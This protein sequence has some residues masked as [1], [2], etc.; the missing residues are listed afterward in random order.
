MVPRSNRVRQLLGSQ[1]LAWETTTVTTDF[2]YDGL[3]QQ[4]RDDPTF[5]NFFFRPGYASRV[6]ERTMRKQ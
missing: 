5:H 3:I 4:Q 1:N 6:T 2:H